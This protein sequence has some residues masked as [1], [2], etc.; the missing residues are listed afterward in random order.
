MHPHSMCVRAAKTLARVHIYTISSESLLPT[1]VIHVST[2]ISHVDSDV[3]D[4]SNEH[5]NKCFHREL[6]KS[7]KSTD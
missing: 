2:K 6:R 4:T 3:V 1:N 5:H 7:L